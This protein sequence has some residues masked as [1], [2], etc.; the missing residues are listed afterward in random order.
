MARRALRDIT[1]GSTP[2]GARGALD[3][4]FC[5]QKA[6]RAI[7]RPVCFYAAARRL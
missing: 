1:P 7:A 4:W 5:K 2:G 3:R 6:G